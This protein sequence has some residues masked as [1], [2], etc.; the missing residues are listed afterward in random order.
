[1]V[2]KLPSVPSA[3][4]THTSPKTHSGFWQPLRRV[5]AIFFPS[6]DQLGSASMMLEVSLVGFSPPGPA[7]QMPPFA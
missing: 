4:I 6:G 7:T 3:S 5:N 1:L 2:T